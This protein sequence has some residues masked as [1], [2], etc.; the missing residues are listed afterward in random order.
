MYLSS[1]KIKGFRKLENVEV[2]FSPNSTFLIG[3]N[4]AGKSSILAALDLFLSNKDK[5]ED[6]NFYKQSN[7]ADPVDIIELEGE[8]R[9]INPDLI[10][11]PEWKGFNL[12]RIFSDESD[13]K[14]CYRISYKKIFERGS[15]CKFSMLQKPFNLKSHYG[16]AKTWQD[17]I[18]KGLDRYLIEE[19]PDD[20]L[21]NKYSLR[22]YSE[23]VDNLDE[24][25]EIQ[26]SEPEWVEN[27]GGFSANVISKLPKVIYIKPDDNIE[28]YDNKRGALVEI[29]NEIFNSIKDSS[30]AYKNAFDALKK[31]ES[32]FNITNSSSPIRSMVDELNGTINGIF[33]GSSIAANINLSCENI[34]HPQ[35]DI[36]LGS[37][38]NT[39]VEYQG[40]GQIRSAVLALLQYKEKRDKNI[41]RTNRDLII[42]FEEPELYLHPNA[43]YM[44]RE[45]IYS[46]SEN[47]QIV[48]STHSPYMID[49]SKDKDQILNKLMIDDA[50]KVKIIPFNILEKYTSL[51]ENDKSYLKMLLKVD[52]DFARL[53][54]AKNILIVEGDTE[55]IV[56]SQILS[57]LEIE[58]RNKIMA[59]WVILKARGKPVIIS[60]INYLIALGINK[61]NIKVMHDA[62]LNND[63]AKKFNQ[64]IK[65]ALDFDENLFPL[66]NCIEDE[67][68]YSVSQNDKP[69]KAYIKTS[70][71]NSLSD[72]PE[73]FLNKIKQIF[74]IGE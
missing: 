54:F 35:Y 50:S 25:Y 65:E 28:E 17:L 24:L 71:W 21:K 22:Q 58:K 7:E 15:K 33:P 39:K 10:K 12:R 5:T 73:V 43:A 44:M 34:L 6:E 46:L 70:E 8:F 36:E 60:I 41:K 59:D 49:L 13:G 9:D 4:N 74:N 37:N 52:S 19:I 56:L 3:I 27:P 11:N 16:S 69:Y 47:N 57:L 32:E 2:K 51:I 48:C 20:Q 62:D 1:L 67:L 23:I 61:K 68:G 53:F 30:D 42:A 66:K 18:D 26:N 72:I 31:L 38:I 14:K 45:V 40:S 55:I 29:L 64:P 63:E